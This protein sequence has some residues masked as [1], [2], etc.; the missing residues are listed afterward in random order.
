MIYHEVPLGLREEVK[1]S[2]RILA[3]LK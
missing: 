2:L 1:E 3:E